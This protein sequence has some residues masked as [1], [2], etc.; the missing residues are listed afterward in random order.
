M[1]IFQATFKD[2]KTGKTKAARKW[3]YAFTDVSG[4]RRCVTLFADKRA[5]E[6]AA[7][8]IERLVCLA[9]AQEPIDRAGHEFIQTLPENVTACLARWGV[10]PE[11]K[12]QG[13]KTL[14]GFLARYREQLEAR[15]RDKKYISQTVSEIEAVTEATRARYPKDIAP[16]KVEKFLKKKRDAGLSP[17]AHNSYLQSVRGFCNFLYDIEALQANPLGRINKLSTKQ[18]RRRIHRDLTREEVAALFAA[19]AA[20]P[21]KHFGLDPMQ[22][23]VVFMLGLRAGLRYNETRLMERRDFDLEAGTF[24]VRAEVEK[25]KRGAKLPLHPELREALKRYFAERPCLPTVRPFPGWTDK[26]GALMQ[27]MCPAAG[28][29]YENENGFADF[30][31]FRV[32]FCGDLARAGVHPNV[33]KQ[34]AR[35]SSVTLT[36]DVYGRALPLSELSRAVEQLA[37]LS[38]PSKVE[39]A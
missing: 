7:R 3:S 9:Q 35:H 10:I 31:A 17:R 32:T 4:V 12:T 26:G 13:M 27:T 24:T 1:R 30:H 29:S 33:A 8:S 14:A 36:M 37:S 2:R 18:D 28:V 11:S 15:G 20:D 21:A 6:S 23:E 5:T 19:S 25:A 34:L 38:L 16:E 22:R 39:T